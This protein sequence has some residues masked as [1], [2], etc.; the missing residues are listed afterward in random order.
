MKYKLGDP[1]K[2]K[3]RE[4]LNAPPFFVNRF[5]K[6]QAK[7][8]VAVLEYIELRAGKRY[9]IREGKVFGMGPEYRLT[10]EPDSVWVHEVFLEEV[11]DQ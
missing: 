3:D 9:T 8:G 11:N 6:R 5:G 2:V 1:V 4:Q 10:G 7:N